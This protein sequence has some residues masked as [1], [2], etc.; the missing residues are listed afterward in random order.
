MADDSNKSNREQEI[1]YHVP[2]D[3]EYCYRDFFNVFIGAGDVVIEFGNGHRGMP[4]HVSIK[5]RVVMTVA[6]AFQLNQ[7]LQKALQA[8]QEKLKKDLQKETI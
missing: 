2:A 6:G 7:T 4:G 8:A 1:K 3:L 5:N